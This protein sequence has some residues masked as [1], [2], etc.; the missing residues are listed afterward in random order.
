MKKNRQ[1]FLTLLF[2]LVFFSNNLFSQDEETK[3]E[4]SGNVHVKIFSNFHYQLFTDEQESAFAVDRAYFG[5]E[6]FMSENF[7]VII[8]LDI[9]SP[10]QDSQYDILKRYAYFKNA[11]L[12]YKKD[13]LT[14]SF[15][16]I[17]LY[18]FKVQEKFWEHRYIYLS[19][20]DKHKFGSSADLGAST[21]YKF[22]DFISADL[23]IMN[24]EGYNQLQTD[25]TYK[26]GLGITILPVKGLTARFY[27]D[28][29]EQDEIQ[30]T[31]SSFVGYD[32]NKIA[33]IGVEYN[34]QGN[35]K[36]EKDHDLQGFSTYTSYNVFEKW[37]LFARYDKLWS[38]TIEGEPYD[39]NINK[40]GSAI[41]A[42][43]QYSPIKN[44]KIAANYQDWY[45]YAQNIDNKSYFYLNFE[46]KF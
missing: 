45:P 6:Y 3:F 26:S 21:S 13:K 19:F 37:E 9:G 33:R 40:D 11:A 36:Y 30:S 24:G 10:N 14:L 4:P 23:T 38:N 8:K 43:I 35:N 5:Y 22:N 41:I 28:Y 20:Q 15:G 42:G 18:Q 25:N 29:T 31:W 17:D 2:S 12:I 32:F 1:I 7:S 16:I 46:Y 34:Y 44:I 39:W 27:V